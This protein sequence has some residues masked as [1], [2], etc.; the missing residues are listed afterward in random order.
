MITETMY[1]VDI[2][3]IRYQ[4]N[5]SFDLFIGAGGGTARPRHA[6]ARE[7]SVHF[8]IPCPHS[9]LTP[10]WSDSGAKSRILE[11]EPEWNY[12]EGGSN[13]P[14]QPVSWSLLI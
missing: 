9:N 3:P 13:N 10:A 5:Q 14:I 2:D 12:R 4:T 1:R 11:P 6:N 8:T 7:G